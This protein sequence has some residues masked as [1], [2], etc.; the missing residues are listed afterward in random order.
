MND[1]V[2]PNAFILRRLHSITG[3]FITLY[4]IE[5]LFVNSQAALFFGSDGRDFINSVNGIHSLPYLKF[6]EICLLGIPIA[7]HGYY[8]IK[9]VRQAA[10]NSLATDG[11]APSLPY[12]SRNQAYTWQRLTSWILLF[13]ILFHVYHMRIYQYPE[14]VQEGSQTAFYV[15]VENDPGYK[16]LASRLAVEIEQRDGSTYAKAKDFGTAELLVVRESFKNPITMALYTLFVLAACFHGFNGLWTFCLSWGVIITEKSQRLALKCC[17]GLM[18][19]VA[20]LG[21]IAIYG[22]FWINLRA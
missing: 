8:G 14:R 5:H 1:R 16:T 18:V 11:S 21:L 3:L 2:I 9:I 20:F 17:Y 12:Y 6:I 4:L 19:L 13:G 7:F 15:A 10:Y 22:T